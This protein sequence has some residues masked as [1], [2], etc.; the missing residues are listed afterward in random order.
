MD[1]QDDCHSANPGTEEISLFY[2]DGL[3]CQDPY[4]T[5]KPNGVIARATN[6]VGSQHFRLA[7]HGKYAR[8]P[9]AARSASMKSAPVRQSIPWMNWSFRQA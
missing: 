2:K 8:H 1:F 3:V 7:G 5:G 4:R 9:K 6:P